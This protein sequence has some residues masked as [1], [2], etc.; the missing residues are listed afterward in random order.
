MRLATTA[1]I[2]SMNK[3]NDKG[4]KASK[5]KS[6]PIRPTIS[7][8]D[9]PK[10]VSVDPKI[11]TPEDGEFNFTEASTK[12]SPSAG[13]KAGS[14]RRSTTTAGPRSTTA[15]RGRG[16]GGKKKDFELKVA[17]G[18]IGAIALVAVIGLVAMLSGGNSGSSSK[19]KNNRRSRT[20]T[21][22]RDPSRYMQ[23][24]AEQ[25]RLIE[26]RKNWSR[27]DVAFPDAE[28]AEPA[29]A[30]NSSSGDFQLPPPQDGTGS[31]GVENN[32][33]E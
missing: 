9:A 31:V 30:E 4:A 32:S 18:T 5:K 19:S 23:T 6:S 14:G 7:N 8:H 24:S 2:T 17:Y 21:E 22:R 1:G 13:R 27:G 25:R 29:A 26:Q 28:D 10:V 15:Q 33:L 12:S 3:P 20:A 16:R 11:D